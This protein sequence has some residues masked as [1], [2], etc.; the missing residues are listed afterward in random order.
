[1]G[2]V[3][4]PGALPSSPAAAPTV[5]C[6]GERTVLASSDVELVATD[7]GGLAD[8]NFPGVPSAATVNTWW[9]WLFGKLDGSSTAGWVPY[10]EGEGP[11]SLL[12]EK[13]RALAVGVGERKLGAGDAWTLVSQNPLVQVRQAPEGYTVTRSVAPGDKP[14]TWN[15]KVRVEASQ[16]VA[17]PVWVGMVD[18]VVPSAATMNTRRLSAA[19]DGSLEALDDP[20]AG[21]GS[22]FSGPLPQVWNEPVDWVGIGDQY[23]V[24]ALAPLEGTSGTLEL[25]RP[26]EGLLGAFFV[27]PAAQLLPG[28]PVDLSFAL[29]TGPKELGRLAEFGHALDEAASLG[30]FGL[31]AKILLFTLHMFQGV[32]GNWGLS[33]LALTFLV[34]LS[35]YPLTRKAVVAGRKMQVLQPE[36]KALQERFADDKEALNRETMALFA[37]H[38]VNPLGGCFPILVQMPV[39][40]AL[41]AAISYEPALFHADF[42]YLQDLSSPDPYGLLGVLIVIG[43]YVQQSMTP[44]TGMDPAQQQMMKLMPLFFGFMMFSMPAGLSLYYT[45]NTVLAI[46]QQWYNTRS[47]PP[48]SPGVSHASS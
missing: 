44:M 47:I 10:G 14:D 1:T 12:G 6:T 13:G 42:L 45:L 24:A 36:M 31:F 20:E 37:R 33:I 32:L 38:G 4:T 34:R 39:F 9:G 16:P 8:V 2:A 17:G 7:C 3:P 30:I 5:A 15:V 41:Y 29:Y 11:Q 25:S 27:S 18:E 35:L 22:M 40:F 43:M 26:A 19:V 21:C 48:P 28:Q 23:Y 46:A